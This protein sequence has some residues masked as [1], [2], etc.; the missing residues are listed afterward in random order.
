M[1]LTAVL[2]LHKGQRR[3]AVLPGGV[4]VESPEAPGA[5]VVAI[6][7]N[8]TSTAAAAPWH[9]HTHTLLLLRRRYAC[10][11]NVYFGSLGILIRKGSTACPHQPVESTGTGT[12]KRAP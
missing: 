10:L 12:E 8:S 11:H 9:T 2:L 3:R 7:S 6:L 5:T 1:K 4:S